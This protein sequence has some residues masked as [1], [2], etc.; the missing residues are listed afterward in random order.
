[1]IDCRSVFFPLETEHVFYWFPCQ[2][3]LGHI[4]L[5][6]VAVWCHCVAHFCWTNWLDLTRK[7]HPYSLVAIG[8]LCRFLGIA[9]HLYPCCT[10]TCASIHTHT[11]TYMHIHTQTFAYIHIHAHTYTYI[12]SY[13]HIHTQTYTYIHIHTNSYQYIPIH[14]NTYQYIPIHT[15]TCHYMPIHANSCQYIPI[16]TITYHNI[17]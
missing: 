17:P 3:S 13:I 2:F 16:H 14:T 11:Y 1:M 7:W 12:N 10:S 4:Q 8:T 6:R 5:K 9:I 15:N